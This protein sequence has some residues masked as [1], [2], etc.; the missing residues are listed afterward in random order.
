MKSKILALFWTIF[1][2]YFLG[3]LGKIRV[4]NSQSFFSIVKLVLL[5]GFMIS[6]MFFCLK[7]FF[8]DFFKAKVNHKIILITISIISLFLADYSL[9]FFYNSQ[10]NVPA[11]YV[12]GGDYFRDV[13]GINWYYMDF[14]GWLV[15]MV[16]FLAP[17]Y[18]IIMDK[19]VRYTPEDKQTK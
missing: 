10:H 3:S 19:F 17:I 16:L 14:G 2:L 8:I 13:L 12:I 11:L 15:T 5:N 4:E 18:L 1:S 7:S 9:I 6:V